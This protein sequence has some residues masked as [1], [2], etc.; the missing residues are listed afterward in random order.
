MMI[1][2]S[3]LTFEDNKRNADTNSFKASTV[4]GIM[5]ELYGYVP[6]DDLLSSVNNVAPTEKNSRATQLPTLS[7]E[8]KP[9]GETRSFVAAT[10]PGV[11]NF[12]ASSGN[13]KRS[14]PFIIRAAQSSHLNVCRK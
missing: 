11:L 5:N 14:F 6:S 8:L 9:F 4:D 3:P 7:R 10:A 2:V 13:P 12:E 1:V